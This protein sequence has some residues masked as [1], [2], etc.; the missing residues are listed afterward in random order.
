MQDDVYLDHVARARWL[1]CPRGHAV[2]PVFVSLIVTVVGWLLFAAPVQAQGPDASGTLAL[3]RQPEGP[4]ESVAAPE[5]VA[6]S[7]AGQQACLVAWSLTGLTIEQRRLLYQACMGTAPTTDLQALIFRLVSFPD[8]RAGTLAVLLHRLGPSISLHADTATPAMLPAIARIEEK[9]DKRLVRDKVLAGV[10]AEGHPCSNLR[11]DIKNYFLDLAEG[12]IPAPPF[13]SYTLGDADRCL[14][15]T[16]EDISQVHLL[17]VRADDLDSLFVSAGTTTHARLRWLERKDFVEFEGH[18]LAVVAVPRGAP[19]TLRGLAKNQELPIVWHGIVTHDQTVWNKPFSLGCIS[20]SARVDNK[21]TLLLDG[22][23][24]TSEQSISQRIVNVGPGDHELIAIE[25]YDTADGK[26]CRVRYREVAQQSVRTTTRNLCEDLR[27]DLKQQDTVSLLGVTTRDSCEGSTVWPGDIEE[28]AVR[29]LREREAATGRSFKDLAAYAT[30]TGALGSLKNQLNPEDGKISGATTG[31]DGLDLLGSA[32]KEAWR[33][34]IDSLVSLDLRCINNNQDGSTSFSLA[35]K[36]VSVREVFQRQRGDLEGLNLDQFIRQETVSFDDPSLINGSVERVIDRL[37]G[38]PHI[39]FLNNSRRISYR[40]K[41]DI[42]V[43]SY[44]GANHNKKSNDPYTRA[45]YA[46]AKPIVEARRVS[47]GRRDSA[48]PICRELETTEYFSTELG[49][50]VEKLF[51]AAPRL[52]IVKA[53]VVASERTLDYSNRASVKVYRVNVRAPRPL[54][55]LMIARWP[56]GHPLAG[57]IADA[58]CSELYVQ[59]NEFWGDVGVTGGIG[60]HSNLPGSPQIL[61]VRARFGQT[62]YRPLPFLGFGWSGG[63]AFQRS[64]IADGLPSW[65]DVGAPPEG[66]TDPLVW[67]RHS[68]LVGPTVEARTRWPTIPVELR[69]RFMP[70]LNT[71]FLDISNINP[72]YMNFLGTTSDDTTTLADIGLDLFLDLTFSVQ[73]KRVNINSG[74]MLGLGSLDDWIVGSKRAIVTNGANL[75]IGF[76]L[77]IGGVL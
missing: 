26:T 47:I 43:A 52:P 39:Q 74:L 5:P 18:Q 62:Y 17:T 6:P 21:T 77:G 54:I 45:E 14:G 75:F 29:A 19:V 56:K 24:L 2:L 44:G 27:L 64:Q 13:A 4:Q 48:P 73:A 16:D 59:T 63:Y 67:A 30:L 10:N 40:E 36:L 71:G 76:N 53:E 55:Y 12:S 70:A 32:A 49:Q 38:L 46:A 31:A 57:K 65:V 28:G 1:P 33:Q 72:N 42:R 25:C 8:W 41:L 51:E 35:A 50:R 58:T 22:H 61:Y 69:A 23:P 3:P 37:F 60:L 34:G 11:T 7:K 15:V 68:L 9:I 20:L 66:S